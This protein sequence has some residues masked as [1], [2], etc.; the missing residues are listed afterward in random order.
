MG[1]Y[2]HNPKELV[3]SCVDVRFLRVGRQFHALPLDL[4]NKKGQA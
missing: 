4:H 3:A 1:I 2:V